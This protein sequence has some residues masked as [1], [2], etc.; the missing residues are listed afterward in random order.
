MKIPLALF[1]CTLAALAQAHEPRPRA[2]NPNGPPS[3][4]AQMQD[5]QS[6]AY[7]ERQRAGSQP[8]AAQKFQQAPRSEPG[9]VPGFEPYRPEPESQRPP[10]VSS[11][12]PRSSPRRWP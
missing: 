7:L 11:P 9:L 8:S 4:A 6:E 2:V 10:F 1:L 5:V 3:P 12:T